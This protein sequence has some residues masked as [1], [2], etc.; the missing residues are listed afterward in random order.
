[1]DLRK[2]EKKKFEAKD[3]E[4]EAQIGEELLPRLDDCVMKIAN[5]RK[6]LPRVCANAVTDFANH[7]AAYMSA[8]KDQ[9][10]AGHLQKA[11]EMEASNRQSQT[12]SVV[13]GEAQGPAVDTTLCAH[14]LKKRK[15]DWSVFDVDV[16]PT[17]SKVAR[18]G[19]LLARDFAVQPLSI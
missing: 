4:K 1:M 13:H 11:V 5:K 10:R 19:A 9:Q 15:L 17:R 3:K 6:R 7:Q 18:L 16:D 8:T 12:A 2:K 14:Y